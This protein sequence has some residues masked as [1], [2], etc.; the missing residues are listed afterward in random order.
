M[1][2]LYLYVCLHVSY[3]VE[4]VGRW[5]GMNGI[6]QLL[7]GFAPS[8]GPAGCRLAGFAIFDR[9]DGWLVWF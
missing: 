3:C 1:V 5:F 8:A 9:L 6:G 2:D 7:E 4:L